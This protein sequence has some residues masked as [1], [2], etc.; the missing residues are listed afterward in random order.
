MCVEVAPPPEGP[1]APELPCDWPTSEGPVGHVTLVLPL[2]A[3]SRP[4]TLSVMI[5]M[6][7]R[8]TFCPRIDEVVL[9]IRLFLLLFIL[10]SF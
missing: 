2:A 1:H 3:G 4:L 6:V 8:R 9:P 10:A 7:G 5:I